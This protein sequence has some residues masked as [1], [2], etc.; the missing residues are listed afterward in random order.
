ML[1]KLERTLVKLNFSG[2]VLERDQHLWL[3]R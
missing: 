1:W 3:E 2:T